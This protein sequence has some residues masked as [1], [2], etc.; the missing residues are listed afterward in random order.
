MSAQHIGVKY[1][2]SPEKPNEQN[3]VHKYSSYKFARNIYLKR[4]ISPLN[5]LSFLIILSF[6]GVGGVGG[7]NSTLLLSWDAG[8]Q[9]TIQIRVEER[10]EFIFVIYNWILVHSST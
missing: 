2:S 6:R 1:N 3:I 10:G 9:T 5:L 7:V 8:D 4:A